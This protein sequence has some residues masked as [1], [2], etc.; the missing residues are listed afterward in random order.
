M[1]WS[2]NLTRHEIANLSRRGQ[3]LHVA[4]MRKKID[5]GKET[6]G[7]RRDD[8]TEREGRE[9]ARARN[10]RHAVAEQEAE[11]ETRTLPRTTWAARQQFEVVTYS[12]VIK[13]SGQVINAYYV[14]S[15]TVICLKQYNVGYEVRAVRLGP[16]D[17]IKLTCG[18]G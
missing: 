18:A 14:A 12:T 16:R 10:V 4:A 9:G 11:K 13:K 7:Q 8:G 2:V 5:R 6:E 3:H 17:L 15:L 1:E